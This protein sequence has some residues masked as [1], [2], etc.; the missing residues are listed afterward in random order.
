MQRIAAVFSLGFL[1]TLAFAQA[2]PARP[3]APP[4]PPVALSGPLVKLKQ[5]QV[6]GFVRDDVN[7]FRALPFA[8]PP[9]GDLRWREPKPPKSWEGVRAANV[10]GSACNQAEDCLFLY[11]WR[12][13]NADAKSKL[14]VFMWIHG[15]GFGGGSGSG[16]D[17]T[18]FAKQGVIL[19]SINYRLGRAGWFAHP[20]LTKE[21]PK[22]LLG[23][24]G[25][26]DQI[27][28]LKW[29]QENIEAF[30]GNKRNVTIGGGSAGA[31][32]V[33]YLMMAPQAK[34]LFNKVISESG[35][36][37]SHAQPLHT[38][39]GSPSVEDHGKGFA[40]RAG[41]KGDD[42]AAAK[43][44]RALPFETILRGAGGVGSNEQPRP[45][46]DGKLIQGTT[47]D[48]FSKG[49]QAK[50]PLLFGGNSDE[51][52]LTRRNTDATERF[53]AIKTRRDEF[54]TL[55]DPEKTGDVERIVAH[56]IS[57][58][59]IGEPAR[60]LAREHSKVA[61]TYLYHFSYVPAT[62]RAE[63]YGMGHGAE[64][65]Y[66]FGR[67]RAGASFDNEGQLI[68]TAANNYWTA[69]IKTGDPGA[70]G[71]VKWPKF[72]KDEA[73][74]EF[75]NNGIPVVRHR[76]DAPRLDWIEQVLVEK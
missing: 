39:D 60:A 46:A 11:V 8:E 6:Q 70:A 45:M 75:P 25:L 4:E 43:A 57:D 44:L 14:P 23:N 7:V 63:A 15:G 68:A 48:G 21:N 64:T 56:M 30:G 59:T 26:M 34:G 16:S 65:S 9:V 50:V 10:N 13:A 55:F 17:G 58:Q 35:F 54:L 47:I 29:I 37:R 72:G 22:G 28:A 3:Q 53:S 51:G 49:K 66:V 12:P 33:Q 2:P 41:I 42:A 52:S 74:L 38:D 20:A 1:S 24:Y 31:M 67:A 27:A 40:E 61:P 69:F 71:G 76:F 62:Q 18:Q 19:V 36:A 5:G 32:S 73:L